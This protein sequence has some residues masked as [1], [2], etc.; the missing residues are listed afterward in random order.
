MVPV[1]VVACRRR[2][3]VPFVR[4]DLEGLERIETELRKLG[5]MTVVI[6]G[7]PVAGSVTAALAQRGTRLSDLV[8]V[9]GIGDEHLYV[10]VGT[11][12]RAVVEFEGNRPD[13]KLAFM[14]IGDVLHTYSDARWRT[15][16]AVTRASLFV[17]LGMAML[18]S[19]LSGWMDS[20][21][22]LSLWFY[23]TSMALTWCNLLV[24]MLARTTIRPSPTE[25]RSWVTQH[26]EVLLATASA[27]AAGTVLLW[28]R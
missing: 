21:S 1:K 26:R 17:Y 11:S 25:G 19:E 18:A 9:S 22:R 24:L 4:L 6:G 7:Q 28:V 3:V 10:T 15:A 12:S 14:A 20:A 8:L 5:A 23:W 2:E 16:A 13:F 27:L